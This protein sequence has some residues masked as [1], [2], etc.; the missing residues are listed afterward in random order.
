MN[1]K[2]QPPKRRLACQLLTGFGISLA[3]VGITTLGLNYYLIQSNLGKEL[4]QR[5]K[6]ITQGVG[7]STEGLIELGNTTIIKRVAQNYAT[8]PSVIEVAIVSPDGQTLARSGAE[9]QNPPYI[10]VHP[11]LAQILAQTAQ[12]GLETSYRTT[13]EG[14]PV[15]VEVLP[16]SS[17]LFGQVDK[18]GLVIAILDVEELQ[19]QAWQTF[20]TST[21][22]LLIGMAAILTLM[23]VLIQRSILSPLQRLNKAVTDSQ[24]IDQFLMPNELPDNEIQ[25][26]AQTIQAAATRVEAYQKLEQ[27]VAQRQQAEAALIRSEAQL[28]QQAA[29]LETALQELQQAQMQMVQ[30]EKMS[31]LGNLVAGVAHEINNPVG[32][33]KGSLGNATE[34]TQ[35]LLNHLHHYQQAYPTPSAAIQDHA[36]AIDLEFLVEDLP[37]LINSMKGA[38]ARVQDIS[39]SLRTFSRADT[40][41]PVEFNLHEGIDSTILILKYRLKANEQRPAI[42]VVRL[43]DNI[44]VVSCFPGQLNQVFMNIL[45]NAIDALE[46][47]NRRSN[48]GYLKDHP[49]RIVIKTGVTDDQQTVIIRIKDNGIGMADDVK[50]QIFHHLFTT[51]GVG[52]G[53]GLGLAIAHQVVVEKHSGRLDCVSSP[54]NGTEFIIEIPVRQH[55]RQVTAA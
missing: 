5:A 17:T 31:A 24:S 7:F 6:S 38:T 30:A 33:L 36:E 25:F 29:D 45:A 39:T 15:L 21:L 2:L 54:G 50:Q 41:H 32:F 44:P 16:F 4:E 48:S 18:R 12:T 9:L 35:D 27:E 34:Y 46:E 53:T 14:K 40:E 19:Q 51:K 1:Q 43:Y 52:K 13:V 26:L 55:A 22:T 23:A 3:T 11:E 49:N 42:E 28:R 47:S 10:S 20:S 8:Q 37:K